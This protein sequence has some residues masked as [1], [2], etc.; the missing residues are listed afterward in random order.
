ML[1]NNQEVTEGIKG[2][3]KNKNMTLKTQQL[4]TYGLQ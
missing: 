1:L 4:K 2:E 3:I